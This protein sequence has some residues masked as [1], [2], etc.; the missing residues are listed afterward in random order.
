MKNKQFEKFRKINGFIFPVLVFVAYS[1]SLA[2]SY[3][4]IGFLRKYILVDSRF[5]L[6]LVI[7]SAAL[8]IGKKLNS[9]SVLVFEVNSIIILP[10]SL[11]LYL[12]MQFLES[13]HFHN[14]VFSRYHIQQTNFFYLVFLSMVIFL[15]SRIIKQKVTFP[16]TSVIKMAIVLIFAAV[17]LDGT[18]KTVDAAFYSDIY[19]LSHVNASY[20]FK[21]SEQWGAYYDYIKFVKT[22]TPDSASIL[23]PPQELPWLST[24]NVG[25]DRYFLFPRNLGNG[26]SSKPMDLSNYDYVLLVWGEWANA[27]KSTYGWPKVPIKA[28][29]IIYFDS[30]TGKASEKVGN[31]DPV[32]SP[33]NGV[34]GIIKVKK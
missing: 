26:T 21:M 6:I 24:G 12:A 16:E 10:V 11:I 1:F 19:I 23:V 3:S 20:D 34:W 4:Y 15:I 7:I 22:Y 28:E 17:F 9:L 25:L 14:Y 31:Y 27:D 30:G 18:V 8:L 5:F 32:L 33:A 2:E 13:F 29:K